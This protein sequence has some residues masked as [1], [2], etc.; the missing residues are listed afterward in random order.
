M[1]ETKLPNLE[2]ELQEE[3]EQVDLAGYQVT[4]AIMFSQVKEAA[5]TL[6]ATKIKFNMACLRKFPGV[7]H[8]QLLISPED[9][10]LIIRPCDKDAPDSLRW[11]IGGG[12]AEL[13]NRDMLCKIFTAMVFD[14]MKWN[15]SSRYKIFGK[16]AV[17]G[18]E[19]LYLFSLTDYEETKW[20]ESTGK[21]RKYLPADWRDFFGTPV[22]QHEQKYRIDLAQGYINPV[23]NGK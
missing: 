13:R 19:Q 20:D 14:L 2:T 9:K 23:Q 7:T 21:N 18:D 16:P 6:W 5:V 1:E 3:P 22:E 11:A 17:S 12:E 8:I 4:K 15:E 10:R